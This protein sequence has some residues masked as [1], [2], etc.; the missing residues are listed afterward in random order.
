MFNYLNFRFELQ[1]LQRQRQRLLAKYR[2]EIT[3]AEAKHA[4][5]EQKESLTSDYRFE[6]DMLD[7]EIALTMTHRWISN[8]RASFFL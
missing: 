6:T 1:K 7:D 2:Q 8:G 3:Q 5:Q 4:T